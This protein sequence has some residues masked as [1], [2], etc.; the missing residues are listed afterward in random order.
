MAERVYSYDEMMAAVCLWEEIC[1]PSLKG[2]PQPW[3]PTREQNGTFGLRAA[4][5]GLAYECDKAWERAQSRFE[6]A[7]AEYRIAKAEQGDADGLTEPQ[8]PGAFDWEFVPT[9][10]RLCVD[11]SDVVKGP[12][13]I[14]P[15]TV[16]EDAS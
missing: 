13:V 9:W 15:T 4:V 14:T 6:E 5:I 1:Q 2:A 7:D 3:E 12:R 16:P 8:E 10:I 11:W